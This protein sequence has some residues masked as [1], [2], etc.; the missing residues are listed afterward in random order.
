[1]ILPLCRFTFQFDN[2]LCGPGAKIFDKLYALK[3]IL[4]LPLCRFTFQFDNFLCGPG[5]KIFDKLKRQNP[6]A[7]SN[8][9]SR[10][11]EN[12]SPVAHPYFRK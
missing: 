8:Q 12:L 9:M 4:I 7:G 10:K 6:E 3:S 1:M 11:F 5:A 2:F